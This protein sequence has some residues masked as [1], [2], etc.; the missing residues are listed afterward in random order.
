MLCTAPFALLFA[1]LQEPAAALAVSV[2]R[3]AAA[4]GTSVELS[5]RAPSRSEALAA[6]ER[7]LRAIEAVEAR[8]STWRT[9][10]E[11]SQLNAT[12]VGELRPL[13][14]ALRADLEACGEWFDAT[15]GAFDPGVG[16][17]VVAWDLRGAG[18]IPGD[19]DIERALRSCGF[20]RALVW[21]ERGVARARDEVRIEEGGFGKGVALDAALSE[22]RQ[23]GARGSVDL[24]GQVAL[25][26]EPR[27]V[28]LADP[29]ARE[30][31]VLEWSIDSGSL[32]TSGNSE[33]AR[34]VGTT[35]VGHL[36]DPRSGR[37]APD[38][39]SVAVRCELAARADAYSTAAYVMG[40]QRALAW[41]AERTDVELVV[42]QVEGA[43]L[44]ARADARLRGRL[45]VLAAGVRLE[46]IEPVR[47]DG[48]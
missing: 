33:A 38:F 34:L 6:S 35:R 47:L 45:R 8:L 44:V 2:E 21:T 27:L 39:G 36:L 46:F 13:S 42:L 29:R 1:A 7:A 26:E 4:M 23:C 24:G 25:L 22:L 12:P 11:L 41:A 19:A 48:R 18:R 3:R 30:R 16:A 31:A 40:P 17:L 32:A 14:A 9:S 20:S 5:V 15:D 43:E 37:P 28:A 10:S